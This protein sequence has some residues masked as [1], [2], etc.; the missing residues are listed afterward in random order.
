MTIAS[1]DIAKRV[2]SKTMNIGTTN[3]QPEISINR[4][5]ILM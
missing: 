4:K 1:C 3:L 2:S 5:E